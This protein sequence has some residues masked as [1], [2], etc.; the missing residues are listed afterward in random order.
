MINHI[1]LLQFKPNITQ[2]QIH[3]AYNQLALIPSIKEFTFGANCSP[4]Q[5]NKGFTHA[6]IM[7]F[8][9]IEG[10]DAYLNHP[11]HIRIAQEVIVPLLE[12][13]LETALTIDYEW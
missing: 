1:V 11:D 10:R 6:F 3:S 12:N 7:R 9:D 4:E 2:D 5:L 13:G 8:D